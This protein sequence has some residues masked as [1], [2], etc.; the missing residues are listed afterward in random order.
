VKCPPFLTGPKLQGRPKIVDQ[1]A[2]IVLHST[3]TALDHAHQLS[4]SGVVSPLN[5]SAQ[6]TQTLVCM[7]MH[8]LWSAC[9]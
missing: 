6:S 9:G 7:R 1:G 8:P 5:L 4:L 3:R 2:Q